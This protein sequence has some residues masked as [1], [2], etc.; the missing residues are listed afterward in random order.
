M[1][2]NEKYFIN[3]LGIRHLYFDNEKDIGQA[4]ENIVY[5][6]LRRRG[7]EVYVGKY[8]DKEV[9]FI[10]VD[11]ETKRYIQVTYLLA[12]KSTIDREFSVLEEIDDNYEKLVI[13]MDKVNRSRNGILHKNIIDFLLEE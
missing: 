6:E 5:L 13:S 9:D 8:D 3:D 12:E 4:L 2:T 10:A 11:A 7:Y 1:K